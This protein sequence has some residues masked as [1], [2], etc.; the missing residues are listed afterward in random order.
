MPKSV[1]KVGI[2]GGGVIG[3]RVADAVAAQ[4]DMEVVGISSRLL[5]VSWRIKLLAK[6]YRIYCSSP[7]RLEAAKKEIEVAGSFSDMLEEAD[8]IID[9]TPAGIGAKNKPIYEKAGIKVVFEGGEKHEVAG[10]SIVATCNYDESLGAQFTR[11]VS[12]NTTAM[13]RVVGGLHK[14]F[15]VKKARIVLFRRCCDVWESHKVGCTNTVV[16]ELHVPSHHAPDVKT[17][18]HDLDIVTMAAKG[19]HNLYHMHMAMIELTKPVSREDVLETLREEPRVVLVYGEDGVTALNSVFELARDL[20]RP[21]GDLYEIPVWGDSVSVEGSEVYM[22]WA[23]PN[24][25]DVIP[26]NV[27]AVRALTEAESDWRKSVEATDKAL[28][29]LSKLY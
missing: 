12:C 20:G 23:C 7:D 1:I 8:V 18:I 15:K 6:K 14:A 3:K 16:P 21:R 29:V 4:R 19:S 5:T 25:S 26:D 13:C 2:N 10:R 9:C 22:V 27:D 11:V 17:V 28:N 24:E